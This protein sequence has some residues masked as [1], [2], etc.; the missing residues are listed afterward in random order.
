MNQVCKSILEQ[1]DK[2]D[3]VLNQ[4]NLQIGLGTILKIKN[5]IYTFEFYQMI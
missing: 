4:G 3:W 5:Q 2:L 1:R